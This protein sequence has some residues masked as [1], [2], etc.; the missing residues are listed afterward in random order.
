[1]YKVVSGA[2]QMRDVTIER[3]DGAQTILAKGVAA[4][5]SIV[6]QGQSRLVPGI[7]VNARS[8]A[9]TEARAV[10]KAQ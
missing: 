4:G 8:E 2:A 6:I 1:M 5:E 7:K 3:I 10:D 9:R